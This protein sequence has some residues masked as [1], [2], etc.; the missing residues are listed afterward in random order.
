[1]TLQNSS[2]LCLHLQC[3][4]FKTLFCGEM[5]F[6][7]ENEAEA[8]ASKAVQQVYQ[9]TRAYLFQFSRINRHFTCF[10][11]EYVLGINNLI[12]ARDFLIWCLQHL[13]KKK[14]KTCRAG[15]E[16]TEVLLIV[17]FFSMFRCVLIKKESLPIKVIIK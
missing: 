14:R 7:N 6:E 4:S 11:V 15:L 5:S 3:L 9:Y 13:E 8:E 1:M 2:L 12:Y 10:I 16:F 17:S